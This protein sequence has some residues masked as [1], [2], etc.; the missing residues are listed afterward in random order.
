MSVTERF[1]LLLAKLGM[2]LNEFGRALGYERTDKVYNIVKR[3]FNPSFE[4]LAD[5]SR[6]FPE[7]DRADGDPDSVMLAGYGSRHSGMKI[8]LDSIRALGIVKASVRFNSM[9]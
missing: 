6:S 2:N 3:R 5:I 9:G 1:N 8:P 7:V 4:V